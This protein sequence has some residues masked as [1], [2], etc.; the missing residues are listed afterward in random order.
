MSSSS[1]RQLAERLGKAD[2]F[3]L[4]PKR[5]LIVSLLY[6]LGPLTAG[7]L[8]RALGLSWG[9]LDSKL[10]SLK[11]RGYVKVKKVITL[12]GP[13]TLIELTEKGLEE[14]EK[15]AADLRRLLE[16]AESFGSQ[17]K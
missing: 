17:P 14:Y 1:L 6:A 11:E 5:F 8:R 15:L 10:R 16:A 7:E 9:D 3:L 12:S 4:N 13:R 2:L